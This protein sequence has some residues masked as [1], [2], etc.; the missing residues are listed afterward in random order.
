[1]MA[2]FETL[3]V[4]GVVQSS[5]PGIGS[6]A[7]GGCVYVQAVRLTDHVV[8]DVLCPS[9]SQHKPA[10]LS[11]TSSPPERLAVCSSLTEL[12]ALAHLAS[13]WLSICSRCDLK[14]GSLGA[15]KRSVPPNSIVC[16][17][18]QSRKR[19]ATASQAVGD[20]YLQQNAARSDGQI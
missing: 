8:V 9:S 15:S 18:N 4:P 1:M 16:A 19:V 11:E 12:A 14:R 10:G 2:A 17:R 6:A 3:P 20:T 7:D 5:H 13:S